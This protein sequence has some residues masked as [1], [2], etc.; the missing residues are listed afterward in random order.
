MTAIMQCSYREMGAPGAPEIPNK[1]GADMRH[2]W[3]SR[4]SLAVSAGLITAAAAWAAPAQAD[5]IDDSF[6]SALDGAG[7]N[8][9]D[10]AD[11]VALGQSVCPMLAQPGSPLVSALSNIVGHGIS[12]AMAEMFASIAVST[13]CPQMMSSLA[14]GQLPNLPQLPGLSGLP[15]L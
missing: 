11:T 7:I 3:T 9:D 12:P 13:Y 15:S 5:S 10:P 1:W 8:Y 4:A 6:L 2:K 14:D